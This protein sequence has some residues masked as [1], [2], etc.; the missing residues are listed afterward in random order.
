MKQKMNKSILQMK[1]KIMKNK[2]MK[3]KIMKNKIMKI[4]KIDQVMVP[5][6]KKN[7]E[8]NSNRH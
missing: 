7:K 4:K 5:L 1:N 6:T 3:N 2:I 8:N